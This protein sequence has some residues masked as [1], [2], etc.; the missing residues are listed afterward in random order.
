M[1][2]EDMLLY[3]F[4]FIKK[5]GADNNVVL[6][7]VRETYD[8]IMANGGKSR[9]VVTPYP[10]GKQLNLSA[11]FTESEVEEWTRMGL[12]NCQKVGMA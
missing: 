1:E 11:L 4:C 6:D 7:N 10:D 12:I 9:L 2:P 5:Y 8:L 3:I